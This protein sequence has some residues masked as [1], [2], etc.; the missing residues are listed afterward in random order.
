M[1]EDQ[2]IYN[3]TKLLVEF[4]SENFTSLCVIYFNQWIK[5]IDKEGHDFEKYLLCEIFL[6]IRLYIT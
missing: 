2:Y 1:R 4:R 5:C 3:L 6:I